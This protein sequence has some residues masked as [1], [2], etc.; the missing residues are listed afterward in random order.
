MVCIYHIKL[1]I[2]I[3]VNTR[4]EFR[5]LKRYHFTVQEKGA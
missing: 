2:L 5:Q 4:I 1:D 3:V